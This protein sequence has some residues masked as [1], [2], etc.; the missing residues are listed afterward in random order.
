MK[1]RKFLIVVIVIIVFGILVFVGC[2]VGG[3]DDD[4]GSGVGL[5]V[6]IIVK[7]DGVIIIELNNF[8]VGDLFVLKYGYGKVIFEMFGFVN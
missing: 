3:G 6:F 2:F 1:F 7:F 4:F 8:Y 5:V